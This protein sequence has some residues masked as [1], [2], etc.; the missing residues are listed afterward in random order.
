MDPTDPV[1]REPLVRPAT[2]EERADVAAMHEANRTA[3]DEAAERYERWLPEAIELIRSG[4]TNLLEPELEA[5]GDLH[6]VCRRAIHF[7][8]ARCR[9]TLSSGTSGPTGVI[10][11]DF[12]PA[13]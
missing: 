2:P 13:C 6:G 3:W 9:D 8:C 5:I 1:E 7:Q 10:G 4:G 12:S 11:V